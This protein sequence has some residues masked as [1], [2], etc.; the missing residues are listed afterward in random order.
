MTQSPVTLRHATPDDAQ[1]ISDLHMHSWQW[2]YRGLIPDAYLDGLSA[3]REQRIEQRRTNLMTLPQRPYQRWWLAELAGQVV[4]FAITDRSRD[5]DAQAGTAE[6]YA[7]YLAPEA[8]GQ[9]VG[10]AL[11][12]HA[13]ADLRQ[14]GFTYATLWV[15]EENQRARTFY[16]AAGW[17][18]DGARKAEEWVGTFLQVI[19]Y[20]ITLSQ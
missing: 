11:F 14:R 17:T 20:A 12:A 16:E 10:R 4:G 5:S 18:P 19:R 2:A 7:I 3:R 15:L 6:V 13:V 9:G 1:A 8:V